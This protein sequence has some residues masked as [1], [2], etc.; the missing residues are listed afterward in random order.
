MRKGRFLKYL[1]A[2]AM[3]V[4]TAGSAVAQKNLKLYFNEFTTGNQGV[5]ELTMKGDVPNAN[6]NVSVSQSGFD[7]ASKYQVFLLNRQNCQDR[8]VANKVTVN[9]KE[10]SQASVSLTNFKYEVKQIQWN[11]MNDLFSDNLIGWTKTLQVSGISTPYTGSAKTGTTGS[12]AVFGKKMSFGKENLPGTNANLGFKGLRS[13]SIEEVNKWI[14]ISRDTKLDD[15]CRVFVKAGQKG[16]A[17]PGANDW[18]FQITYYEPTVSLDGLPDVMYVGEQHTLQSGDYTISHPGAFNFTLDSYATDNSASLSIN[19]GKLVANAVG[20]ATITVTLKDGN[21]TITATKDILVRTLTPQDG[22]YYY[23]QNSGNKNSIAFSELIHQNTLKD[24]DFTFD[25][26]NKTDGDYKCLGVLTSKRDNNYKVGAKIIDFPLSAPAYTTVTAPFDFKATNSQTGLNVFDDYGS[27]VIITPDYSNLTLVTD[28]SASEGSVYKKWKDFFIGTNQSSANQTVLIDN[29]SSENAVSNQNFHIVLMAGGDATATSKTLTSTFYYK[30]IPSIITY[31][32]YITFEGNGGTITSTNTTQTIAKALSGSAVGTDNLKNLTITAPTGYVFKGWN[33]K[34]DGTG[35]HYDAQ[36][37]FRPSTTLTGGEG[38]G[39]VTLYAEW[40]PITYSVSLVNSQ[41]GIKS[42]IV[43]AKYGESMPDVDSEGKE[44][45]TP[46]KVGYRFDGYYYNEGET[47]DGTPLKKYYNADMTSANNWDMSRQWVPLFPHFVPCEYTLTLNHA[48]GTNTIDNVKVTYDQTVPSQPGAIP[49][50]SGYIFEGYYDANGVQ[51]YD[52]NMNSTVV[53]K[54]DKSDFVVTARWTP[55][56]YYVVLSY[57]GSDGSTSS[58]GVYASY[59]EPMPDK[60]TANAILEAPYKKG[61]TFDGFY[62]REGNNANG[63]FEKKYYNSDFSSANN[64]DIDLPNDLSK[65][66]YIWLYPR[67]TAKEYT[68]NLNPNGGSG[69][70]E[71]VLVAFGSPMPEIPTLPTRLGYIFNGYYTES[72]YSENWYHGGTCYYNKNAESEKNWDGTANTTL[73]AHWLLKQY[74]VIFHSNDSRNIS[75]TQNI[76]VEGSQIQNMGF[77]NREDYNFKGWSYTPTGMDELHMQDRIYPNDEHMNE[78]SGEM[79]LYAVW[80]P[81]TYTVTFCFRNPDKV[82]YADDEPLDGYL[83]GGSANTSLSGKITTPIM[84]DQKFEDYMF[85]GWCSEDGK[86]AYDASG[87]AVVGVY[88]ESKNG[89]LVWKLKNNVNFYPQWIKDATTVEIAEL[90]LNNYEGDGVTHNYVGVSV[91]GMTSISNFRGKGYITVDGVNFLTWHKNGNQDNL[92]S[93][94]LEEAPV[95]NID[96]VDGSPNKVLIYTDT[97]EGRKYL[98][99]KKEGGTTQQDAI[100]IENSQP[101]FYFTIYNERGW[102]CLDD[103]EGH[104]FNHIL[105]MKTG[106]VWEYENTGDNPQYNP[107]RILASGSSVSYGDLKS[108]KV[109]NAIKTKLSTPDANGRYPYAYNGKVDAELCKGILYVDMGGAANIIEANATDLSNF[110]GEVSQNCLFFMP[111][112]YNNTLGTNVVTNM[113]DKYLSADDLVITDKVPFSSPYTFSTGSHIASYS[114]ETSDKWGSL[115]LPFP[116]KRSGSDMKF[117]NLYGS[118]D[119]RLAFESVDGDI[120]ANE[121]IACYGSGSF[122]LTSNSNAV[123]PSDNASRE[124]DKAVTAISCDNIRELVEDKKQMTKDSKTWN[125]KGVR[126][127]SYVY[128]TEY[129]GTLPNRAKKSLVYYFSKDKFTYVNSKGRVKFAPFRAYLQAPEGSS[130]KTFSLL[131]FNEDGA[132]DI[133]EIIDGNAGVANGKIYD[134]FGRRVKT[135]L[136]GH[137][138]IVDGKKKQY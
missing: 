94:P 30:A 19:N 49:T 76:T 121:P 86:K 89:E 87:N 32:A 119:L 114:R 72:G 10:K 81:K 127:D 2:M 42:V 9:G 21:K 83:P 58:V 35:E 70:T 14:I 11:V 108:S 43:I 84:T 112:T 123:V 102:I 13:F 28:N 37:A 23:H 117:Y 38:K 33:T 79:H 27:E 73:Y 54:N 88:W 120:P 34:A 31:Y 111:K 118:D 75:A 44:I 124:Y 106:D 74:K 48:G 24:E 128:G 67:F 65:G 40:E 8:V 129:T 18:A 137:I 52:K 80:A 57:A 136:K 122:T 131:V 109:I 45:I 3:A 60:S 116:V 63:Q 7:W 98:G 96:A 36:G 66:E 22:V 107:I 78:E 68:V 64:W 133:T 110:K 62:F 115:C 100:G 90:R 4:S 39:P 17:E 5:P 82:S 105:Y 95:W 69:G 47:A 15:N 16:T 132:T 56:K 26:P 97:P 101:D 50:K 93:A 85:D 12:W 6:E 55:K 1:L 134:L 71:S 53:W 92:L 138:Y 41:Y 103:S 113:G 29:K 25:I 51:Y 77:E 126:F 59:G 104:L 91:S 20:E 99:N 125:F 61:Y 130:A 46:T 135:P